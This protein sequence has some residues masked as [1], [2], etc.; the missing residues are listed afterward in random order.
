[1][2]LSAILG[3]ALIAAPSGNGPATAAGYPVQP[4]VEILT[5]VGGC[6]LNFIYNGTGKQAGKVFGGTAAHCVNKVGDPVRLGATGETFGKAA[7]VG[8]QNTT[9]NDYAFIQVLPAFVS[10]VNP[11]VKGSPTFPKGV[12]TPTETA[13]GDLIQLSGYGLGFGET[14]PTQERREAVMGYDDPSIYDVSG[15]IDWGDSGGP[16]VHIRTGKALGIVSRLCAG[17]CTEEGPTVQGI[18]TRARARGF[19]VSLRTV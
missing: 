15:P 12:T 1:M 3:L 14:Q 11:A 18:L 2:A 17:V 8:D 13:P 5:P 10:R 16:L 6:T 19:T 9:E 7:F 4:G